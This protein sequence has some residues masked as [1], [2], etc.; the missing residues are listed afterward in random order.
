MINKDEVL[1]W[2]EICQ[3]MNWSTQGT[4]ATKSREPYARNRG[5]IITPVTPIGTKPMKYTIKEKDFYTWK[6]L[7][8]KFGWSSSEGS[9][10]QRIY[11]ARNAGVTIELDKVHSTRQKSYYKIIDYIDFNNLEW[12]TYPKNHYYEVCKE[13]YVRIVKNHRI[14]TATSVNGYRVINGIDGHRYQV[15]RMVMETFNPIE[16]SNDY[17]VDHINGKRDDNRLEN[18]RWLT[19]RENNEAKDNNY[20]RLNQRYQKLVLKFGY[21][22]L[23]KIFDDLLNDEQN[24]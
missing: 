21:D 20:A 1:T 10:T 15:H 18:L 9:Q 5:F 11:I 22:G 2:Q 16:N 6:E 19:K 14:L 8:E 3:R 4:G 23:E 7:G 17:I 24:I 12:R 13:G